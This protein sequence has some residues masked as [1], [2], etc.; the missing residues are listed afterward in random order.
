MHRSSTVLRVPGWSAAS[1]AACALTVS[2]VAFCDVLAIGPVD[3]IDRRSSTVSILGQSY[4]LT[5]EATAELS[6]GQ[7]LWIDATANGGA[8]ALRAYS[9]PEANAPGAT[10]LYVSGVVT[11]VS[12]NGTLKL[13]R[14]NVDFTHL[15]SE[16]PSSIAVGDLVGVFGTQPSSGGVLLAD[17]LEVVS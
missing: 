6:I 13:G 15:L 14:L 10:Q 1:I 7:M 11:K 9:L 2:Q 4:V 12:A 3:G 16:G 17:E 8:P 5:P